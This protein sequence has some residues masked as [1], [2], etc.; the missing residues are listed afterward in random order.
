MYCHVQ[1]VLSTMNPAATKAYS[2][3]SKVNMGGNMYIVNVNLE[4]GKSSVFS[5]IAVRV[6]MLIRNGFCDCIFSYKSG[7]ILIAILPTP[8]WVSFMVWICPTYSIHSSLMVVVKSSPC[9][10]MKG[11]MI[12]EVH[13]NLVINA[14][15]WV[16]RGFF[17][18]ASVGNIAHVCGIRRKIYFKAYKHFAYAN[19]RTCFRI[20]WGEGEV[21]AHNRRIR[22][23]LA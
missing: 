1:I 23:S 6:A 16:S 19:T 8:D 3:L 15:R 10:C 14:C 13:E 21:K 9:Q 18:V 7:K 11:Y 12:S 4:N 17:N 5:P 20:K 2:M 22:S